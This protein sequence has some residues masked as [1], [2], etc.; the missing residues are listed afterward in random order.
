MAQ[1]QSA[2]RSYIGSPLS[3]MGATFENFQRNA[4]RKA[5]V[6]F[7]PVSSNRQDCRSSSSASLARS[8]DDNS[9]P[10]LRHRDDSSSSS[11]GSDPGAF[12]RQIDDMDLFDDPD[13]SH[14]FSTS[15]N[16]SFEF[17]FTDMEDG[18]VEE[19][20]GRKERRPNRW[21][22]TLGNWMRSAYYK[23]FLAPDVRQQTYEQSL[24]KQ[25]DF[26]S[27]F[28]VPLVIIDRLTTMFIHRGWLT[29]STRQKDPYKF[30]IR[31]ELLIMGA[32]EHLGTRKPFRQFR[33]VTG[34]S[35]SVHK[36]FT[37]KFIECISSN[38]EEWISFP[39]TVEGIKQIMDDYERQLLPV[40]VGSIDVVH[41]KWSAC[42]AGDKVRAK[43]KEKFPT[44]AFEVVT[45]NNRE[46]L[47]VASPQFGTRNDQHIVRLDPTVNKLRKGWYKDLVWRYY[48]AD[49]N[50]HQ[51]RGVYLICDGGYLRWV[52]LVCPFT[53]GAHGSRKRYFSDNLESVRKDV[54]CTFGILKARW[55]ILE[56]GLH[57]RDINRCGD[58]F[59]TCCCLHN[60]MLEFADVTS[61]I[62]RVGR[63]APLHGDA[64]YLEGP[65]NAQRRRTRDIVN[66]AWLRRKEVAEAREWLKRREVL[67]N[68]HYYMKKVITRT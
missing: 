18:Y 26:R 39:D 67:A 13:N 59:M 61:K 54:E 31:C 44:V 25:S 15:N 53:E 45:N 60:M 34:L 29:P 2:L 40:R 64:I 56:Y 33:V 28:R 37:K 20:P 52:T 50:V 48:D 27:H 22:Y 7:M 11:G 49:G 35:Y 17:D 10:S 41:C 47:G 63:G 12:L 38:K 36:N 32:L 58:V 9:L 23:N 43:G 55:R 19:C 1:S 4:F 42:P 65:A 5:G 16:V 14:D 3:E 30:R 66:N 62:D 6:P 46:I 21:G 57:Y 8:L 68:H 24:D 51:D